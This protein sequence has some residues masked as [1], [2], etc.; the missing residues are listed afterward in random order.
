MGRLENED[1]R[2]PRRYDVTLPYDAGSAPDIPCVDA[3]PASKE[4]ASEPLAPGPGL[5]PVRQA[6]RSLAAHCWL[7]NTLHGRMCKI[8][9]GFGAGPNLSLLQ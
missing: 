9:Q 2:K 5:N 6:D 7:Q 3:S 4:G 8:K 1:S